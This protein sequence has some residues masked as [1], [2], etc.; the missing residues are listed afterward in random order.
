MRH[1]IDAAADVI[2]SVYEVLAWVIAV[3]VIACLAIILS[4]VPLGL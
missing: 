1:R 4:P 2:A 3:P